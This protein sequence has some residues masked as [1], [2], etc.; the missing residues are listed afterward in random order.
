MGAC[1]HTEKKPNKETKRLYKDNSSYL[2][3]QQREFQKY[4]TQKN[5]PQPIQKKAP[6]P[7]AGQGIQIGGQNQNQMTQQELMAKAAEERLAKQQNRGLTQQ[8]QIEYEFK[9]K[10]L[11]DAEYYRQQRGNDQV[12]LYD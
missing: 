4:E 3:E 11:A 5:N 8:A 1:C 12:P 9:Q 2:E 6:K 10:R 7:M